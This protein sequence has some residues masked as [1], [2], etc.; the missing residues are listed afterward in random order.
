MGGDG[1]A[2]EASW[3]A[4]GDAIDV[5]KG[6]DI[7]DTDEAQHYLTQESAATY[8]PGVVGLF[9]QWLSI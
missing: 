8:I 1:I 4:D 6:I 7:F 5:L 9:E 2:D 3:S